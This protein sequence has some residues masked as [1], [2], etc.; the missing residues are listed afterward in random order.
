MGIK[1]REAHIVILL[2]KMP[3]TF[4]NAWQARAA[5]QMRP[6]IQVLTEERALDLKLL[7]SCQGSRCHLPHRR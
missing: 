7:G 5:C 2:D 3:L 1:V 6:S 4:Y